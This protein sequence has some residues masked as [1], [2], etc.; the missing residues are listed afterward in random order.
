[1]FRHSAHPNPVLIILSLR[2]LGQDYVVDTLLVPALRP[3]LS[4]KALS[5]AQGNSGRLK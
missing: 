4:L 1:M 2:L 5:R 3:I